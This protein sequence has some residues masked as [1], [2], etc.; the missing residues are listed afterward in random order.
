MALDGA[1]A[2]EEE[3]EADAAEGCGGLEGLMEEAGEPAPS[4]EEDE[5]APSLLLLPSDSIM[6]RT[7]GVSC[8]AK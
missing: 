8:N 1:A 2:A 3:E 6:R 5:L 7:K 4:G